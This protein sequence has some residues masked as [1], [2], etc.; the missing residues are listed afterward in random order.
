MMRA[1]RIEHGWVQG[2][3]VLV[4]ALVFGCGAVGC[5]DSDNRPP[6]DDGGV[7]DAS[8]DDAGPDSALPDAGADAEIDAT[9]PDAGEDAAMPDATMDAGED[10]GE[11]AA[12]SDA[13]E[14][15]AIDTD[16][17]YG[18]G[19]GTG[20]DSE[21][22]RSLALG[23]NNGDTLV[24]GSPGEAG[25]GAVYVFVRDDVEGWSEQARL[26]SSNRDGMD[27]F[28]GSVGIDGDTIVVGAVGERSNA[29]GVNGDADNNTLANAGAA[30][31]FT[32][33]GRAHV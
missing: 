26:V 17:T 16:V 14:D 11:D 3:G 13:G 30:Y 21:L 23:G 31:V 5:G 19:S 22:G 10:A 27:R 15:A 6:Q 9:V 29:T 4:V 32:Q 18:K 2:F 8:R 12:F 20:P 25:G 1:M 33:I 28:G 7:G 24:I